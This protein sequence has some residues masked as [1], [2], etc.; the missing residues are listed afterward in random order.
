MSFYFFPHNENHVDPS[1]VTV[2]KYD[3]LPT[4]D[5]GITEYGW[6]NVSL[7]FVDSDK[8]TADERQSAYENFRVLMAPTK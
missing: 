1:G 6:G 2:S 3:T 5:F 7:W 4:G 8:F